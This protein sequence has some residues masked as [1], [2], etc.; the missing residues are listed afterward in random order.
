MEVLLFLARGR[1][2]QLR[3]TGGQQKLEKE[4]KLILSQ[5]LQKGI[6]SANKLILGQ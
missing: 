6:S 2:H 1:G 3:N 4:R 5:N